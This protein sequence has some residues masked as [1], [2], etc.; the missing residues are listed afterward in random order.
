MI[1]PDNIYARLDALE[2]MVMGRTMRAT[3]PR[4]DRRLTKAQLAVRRGVSART[5][6]RDVKRGV[7]PPPEIE[8]GRCY[9]WLSILQKHE[10][11]HTANIGN[12]GGD[13]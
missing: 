6:D 1:N 13:S 8:N 3:D 10:R 11:K 12:H 2:A 7:L 4:F 9:W 5:I